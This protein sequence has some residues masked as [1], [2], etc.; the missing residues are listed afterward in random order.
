MKKILAI[1]MAV[2]MVMALS[3]TAFAAEL[4]ATLSL[5]NL[6]YYGG[7]DNTGVTE[8]D[9]GLNC[10]GAQF[11]VMLPVTVEVGETVTI[12]IKGSSDGDFRV[13]LI[14]SA[15]TASNQVY[16]TTDLGLSGGEFDTYVTLTCSDY[17]S[18]GVTSASA[19]SFKGIAYGTNLDNFTITYIGVVTDGEEVAETTDDADATEETADASEETTEAAETTTTTTN[20]DTGVVL[21][22]LPMAVAAAAVVASKRR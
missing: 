21:A 15:N 17:D 19:I 13:W 4:E 12:H 14:D 5:D 2:A 22:V 6:G 10:S 11:D 1:V 8:V 20:A 9:G 7:T 16:S 3:V 18:K